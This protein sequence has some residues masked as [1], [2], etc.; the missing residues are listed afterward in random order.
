MFLSFLT[1]MAHESMCEVPF[2][3]KQGISSDE[4][5]L[6]L[7]TAGTSNLSFGVIFKHQW[8]QGLW[9]QTTLFEN[10]LPQSPNI[11]LLEL[12][13]VAIAFAIWAPNFAG[14]T[15]TLH[16]DNSTTMAF[17]NQM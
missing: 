2:L 13:A 17:I 3:M 12:Y 11:V 5:Q 15:I 14:K 8:A 6:F 4:L 9:S 16:S 7:D 10:M 1:E